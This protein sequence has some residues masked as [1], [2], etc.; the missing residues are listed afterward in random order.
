MPSAAAQP[1]ASNPLLQIVYF[2]WRF[3]WQAWAQAHSPERGRAR[4]YGRG[5]G[6]PGAETTGPELNQISSDQD[7]GWLGLRFR[8]GAALFVTIRRSQAS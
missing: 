6:G 2:F 8:P 4:A 1:Y 5:H 3:Q 7:R